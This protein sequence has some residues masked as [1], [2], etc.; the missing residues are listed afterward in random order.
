M[1]FLDRMIKC[2]WLFVVLL[3]AFGGN[4]ILLVAADNHYEPT[5]SSLD[6]RPI[7]EWYDEAKFGIFIHWGVFAVPGFKSEWFW[8]D[9][10]T[11]RDEACVK[12]MADNFRPDFTYPDFASNFKAEFYDPKQW[13][14]IF[15]A[16]G[17]K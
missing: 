16:S 8:K 3:Q 15:Q 1:L 17:A 10:I 4:C 6:S 11:T 14:D 2:V 7:P 13:A 5:W 9:W 12:F